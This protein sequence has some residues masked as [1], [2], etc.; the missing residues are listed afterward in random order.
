MA[1]SH[2]SLFEE[3]SGLADN[4][5]G[6]DREVYEKFEKN[7]LLP[8]IGEG[9][10]QAS[11]AFFGRDPGRD[12]V[13]HGIPF[14]GAGG[15][16]IRQTLYQHL[17]DVSLPDFA[18]SIRVGDAFF[19]ANTVPY[20]PV[21]NK[22][23]PTRVKKHFQPLVADLLIHHWHGRDIITLGREALFWFAI[24][25][26]HA[27]KRQLEDFW[28][29]DARFVS[30]TEVIM[31]ARDGTHKPVRL[32]PLPHPSPL[33]AAWYKRFPDLLLQRLRQL[34]ISPED[35]AGR[36]RNPATTKDG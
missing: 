19:W 10:P 6:I 15:Q 35:A 12:E 18:A 20:K 32:H 30:S 2:S 7:P 22:A 11:L 9:N 23:W 33:N 28:A 29:D 13:R 25:Q 1:M 36:P 8:I 21:G 27:V 26:E 31:S 5:D 3:F 17:H 4:L 16:K 34:H 24:H 14:I